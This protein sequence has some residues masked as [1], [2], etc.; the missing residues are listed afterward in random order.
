M[1]V[2][3]SHCTVGALYTHTGRLLWFV[4]RSHIFPGQSRR[5]WCT[6]WLGQED[7]RGRQGV[8][9]EFLEERR[10]YRLHVQ[11]TRTVGIMRKAVTDALHVDRLYLEYARVMSIDRES[12]SYAP[13][14]R[15]WH[16]RTFVLF[17]FFWSTFYILRAVPYSRCLFPSCPYFIGI[18]ACVRY[19]SLLFFWLS[20]LVWTM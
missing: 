2:W 15:G 10:H 17:F 5:G 13:W 14:C 6:R 1:Q 12:L 3:R 4:W 18:P 7:R 16:P 19:R 11:V 9:R 8:E 20:F